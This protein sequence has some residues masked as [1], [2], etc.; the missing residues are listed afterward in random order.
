MR[1]WKKTDKFTAID[2]MEERDGIVSEIERL[3]TMVKGI[4]GERL[5]LSERPPTVAYDN[6]LW[7]DPQEIEFYNSQLANIE[8]TYSSDSKGATFVRLIGC[9]ECVDINYNSKLEGG[10]FQKEQS[11]FEAEVTY[12]SDT[13]SHKMPQ[14]SSDFVANII[15][16]S[17][18]ESYK[19]PQFKSDFDATI[20]YNSDTISHKMPQLKSSPED[21]AFNYNSDTTSRKMPQF[22]S[23]IEDVSFN[24]NSVLIG[25]PRQFSESAFEVEIN[26]NSALI[27]TAR[28]FSESGFEAEVTYNSDTTSH[29]MPQF[30][31]TLEDVSFN[32]SSDTTSRKVPQFK[33][34]LE[35]VAFSY[36]SQIEGT[37]RQFSESGFEN[38]ELNY[39]STLEG[40]PRQFSE[41]GMQN[42]T[43]TYNSDTVSAVSY[44][45][46][47][48]NTAGP[49]LQMIVQFQGESAYTTLVSGISDTLLR[50]GMTSPTDLGIEAPQSLAQGPVTYVFNRWEV[51][52]VTQTPTNKNLIIDLETT[53]YLVAYYDEFID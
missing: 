13:T 40:S 21:V 50:E 44:S 36:S 10:Y 31:S 28:Q 34:T 23:S 5:I 42:I 12:N 20:N 9:L 33:S 51:N 35:N 52:G 47:A 39:S 53:T 22:K 19:M 14:L 4:E 11:A 15:Y 41:S 24:Y 2:Y 27:G 25:T 48:R 49:S 7:L 30:K 32:Y 43:L 6:F 16:E 3:D 18:V 38:I 17:G 8:I 1:N 37:P 46:Y 26:Y 45:V 29:K